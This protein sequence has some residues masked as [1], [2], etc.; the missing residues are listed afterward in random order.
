M[1]QSDDEHRTILNIARILGMCHF[2]GIEIDSS[3]TPL[4]VLLE[5]Y[6]EHEI[7]EYEQEEPKDIDQLAETYAHNAEQILDWLDEL[8]KPGFIKYYQSLEKYWSVIETSFN[9][10]GFPSDFIEC[11]TT[12]DT[13]VNDCANILNILKNTKSVKNISIDTVFHYLP[14]LWFTRSISEIW[15]EFQD[16]FSIF[17]GEE[18]KYKPRESLLFDPKKVQPEKQSEN[19]TS[20]PIN[21][22]PKFV[23]PVKS[24]VIT[25]EEYLEEIAS[26]RAKLHEK[27]K[28]TKWLKELY[29][30]AKSGH[31][32]Y[33][34]LQKEYENQRKELIALREFAYRSSK[35]FEDLPQM[36]IAEMQ[37]AI[38][39]KEIVIIGGHV[40]WINKIQ[41]TFR[42][43]VI[44][45]A[46]ASRTVDA[47]ILT[48][49][50]RVYFFTDYIDHTTYGK[51]VAICREKQIPFGYLHGVN[52]ETMTQQIYEDMCE[53]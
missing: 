14:A 35:E 50:K 3:C 22:V 34:S 33:E 8:G 38:E 7:S 23:A 45:P 49:K 26:L 25:S 27:E 43:W 40:N 46:N 1:A 18:A 51:Y 13:L 39:T 28:E 5:T 37:K 41:K 29:H 53:K 17:F 4:Y 20:I 31:E 47:N 11:P 52:I 16:E 15:K 48:G 32:K 10:L 24:E 44:I 36:T 9:Q 6:Y 42:N 2:L 19:K 21:Q 12:S 30:D